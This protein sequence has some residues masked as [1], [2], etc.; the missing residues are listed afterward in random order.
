MPSEPLP[1]PS[2]GLIRK[3][4]KWA[5]KQKEAESSGIWKHWHFATDSGELSS[6]TAYTGSTT[7]NGTKVA[8]TDG[9]Y[10]HFYP[11]IYTAINMFGYL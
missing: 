9:F 7:Q 11:N 5:V 3:F 8:H 4:T 6:I 10:F 1:T 2:S